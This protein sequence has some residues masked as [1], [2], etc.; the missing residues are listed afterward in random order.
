MKLSTIHLLFCL[1]FFFFW[2][3]VSVILQL[4]P[5]FTLKSEVSRSQL[6]HIHSY[7]NPMKQT[8]TA[9]TFC[10]STERKR[11]ILHHPEGYTQKRYQDFNKKG[12]FC[13]PSALL[14]IR[15]SEDLVS[16]GS[17]KYWNEQFHPHDENSESTWRDYLKCHCYT[18]HGAV[19]IVH[20]E[21]P[22]HLHFCSFKQGKLMWNSMPRLQHNLKFFCCSA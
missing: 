3:L 8:S 10:S 12:S 20:L 4:L 1:F 17:R 16:R 11:V 5:Y 13:D 2:S 15:I 18:L 21:C 7:V 9:R 6:W 22:P 19:I 14:N